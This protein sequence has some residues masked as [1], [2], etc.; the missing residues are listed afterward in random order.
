MKK[1]S[2]CKIEKPLSEFT[3]SAT[4]KLGKHHYCKSCLYKNKND[5][6][7][8]NKG[9]KQ[10]LKYK[11]NLSSDEL[12]SMYL[13]QDKKCKICGDKYE[14]ISKHGGLYI[15]HCHSTGKVRGLLCR[16]CNSLLGVAKDNVVILQNAINYLKSPKFENR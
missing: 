4:G 1:C 7:N 9:L 6:Y 11:Y 12:N 8:Y 14:D 3:N 10:R 13:S 2:K 15:D 16:S 5:G